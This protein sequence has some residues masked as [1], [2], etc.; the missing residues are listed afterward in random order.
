MN[1][2]T[3]RLVHLLQRFT[4]SQQG[5]VAMIAGIALPVLLMISAGA[6]DLH[7]A[8]K[9]KSEL[10]DALDAA[11]LAAARSNATTNAEV[12]KVGMASLK[13][14][15]PNYF[16]TNPGDVASFTV[17]NRT[18]VQATA[19]VQVKTIIANVFLPP[20]GQL[21]DDY[22]P[23]GASSNVLRASRN[24]EVAIAL[25]VTGSMSTP[26]NYMPALKDAAKEL[27][28]IVV[29]GNQDPFTTKVALI[30]YAAGVNMGDEA[31]ASAMRGALVGNK[32]ITSATRLEASRRVDSVN[33]TTK[34]FT[35]SNHGFQNG[36][37]VYATGFRSQ[38][39][40]NDQIHTIGSVTAST[41]KLSGVGSNTNLSTTRG[42]IQ[43]CIT[44]DCDMVVTA[45]NHQLVDREL[46]R[47]SGTSNVNIN[48]AQDDPRNSRYYGTEVRIL[49][50][51]RFTVS[52]DASTTASFSGNGTLTCGRDGCATRIFTNMNGRTWRHPSSTCVS[53]RVRGRNAPSDRAPGKDNY[54]GR[55]YIDNTCP[56]EPFLPLT[57]SVADLNGAVNRLTAGGS[58]AGQVGTEMAWYAISPNFGSINGVSPLP[59]NP[60][61]TVKA[62]ILMTDGEFNIPFCEGVIARD[63]LSEGSGSNN[64]KINCNASNGNAFTQAYETCQAMKKQGIVVYSVAFN[65][66]SNNRPSGAIDTAYEVMYFCATDPNENFFDA[67]S[68]T[69]LKEAF[70]QIGRD[71]TRLRIAR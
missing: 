43:K 5:N 44:R 9:V 68:G 48:T 42:N 55:V 17:N 24:V 15:M 25:D 50:D 4:R 41:F 62:V 22:L 64:H 27:I 36:D 19:T 71:I 23:M 37:R 47:I 54:L 34:V 2:F 31:R 21:F 69:D 63:A 39:G 10:Q 53:E 45:D 38:S 59:N 20:Y 12:Q 30:P 49:D 16:L 29:Q 18:E 26:V 13:A 11:T 35:L 57:N 51:N 65:L 46:V 58:T 28:S 67:A 1:S 7:N 70:K 66:G 33:N 32:T 3:G 61:E 60:Q 56:S 40:I 14:N 6:I 52:S 8:A